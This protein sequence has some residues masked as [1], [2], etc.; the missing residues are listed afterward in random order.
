MSIGAAANHLGSVQSFHWIFPL[1]VNITLLQLAPVLCY[2]NSIITGIFIF[3]S[4]SKSR[5]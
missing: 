2:N 1:V 4:C 5:K 3:T